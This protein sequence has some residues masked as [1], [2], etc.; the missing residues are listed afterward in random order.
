M[1]QWCDNCGMGKECIGYSKHPKKDC[2][3]YIPIRF[4]GSVITPQ[5]KPE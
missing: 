2:A 4:N 3:C 5:E 1:T